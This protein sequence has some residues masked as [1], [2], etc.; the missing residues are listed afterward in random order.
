VLKLCFVVCVCMCWQAYNKYKSK[1]LRYDLLSIFISWYICYCDEIF[2]FL[3]KGFR[4]TVLTFFF[5]L[6][7][8][9]CGVK[10]IW[11]IRF[12][13]K[14]TISNRFQKIREKLASYRIYSLCNNSLTKKINRYMYIVYILF[15]CVWRQWMESM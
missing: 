15:F 6:A 7:L 4:Y 10:M 1:F 12:H 9:R 2:E 5:L 11:K 13:Q 14:W 8:F 3:I